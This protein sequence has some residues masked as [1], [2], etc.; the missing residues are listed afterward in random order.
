M[1][2]PNQIEIRAADPAN[3]DLHP[4][5]LGNQ[6]HGAAT[7]P[8]ASDHTFGIADLCHPD[9]QFFAAYHA[10]TPLGCGALKALPDGR[11]EVKS[12]FV[13][14]SARGQGL[15]RQLMQY[16]AQVAQ[17]VGFLALV[18]ETGSPLCPGYDAARALY[19]GLGYD[20]CPPFGSY[21]EDPQ[22]VFMQ[23]PLTSSN[24]TTH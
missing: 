19:E 14:Q 12:V 13:S 11:A 18:L 1:T 21:V 16:L 9:I 22:S 15:A 6:R 5:I 10:G 8:A 17:D 24:R 3:P 2:R 20:Y 4:L 7:A 23:L